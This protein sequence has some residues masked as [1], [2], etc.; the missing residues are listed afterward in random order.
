MVGRRWLSGVMLLSLL[1]FFSPLLFF[2]QQVLAEPAKPSDVRIVIDISGS[3][4][5]TDPEN[6]RI[7]AVNLLVELLPDGSQ[8]GIWTFGR[9]VNMLVPLATVDS[10]WRAQAKEK[11]ET[12]NSVGLQTNLTEALQ[13]ASWKV[14][15]DSGFDH[16]VILLTD[17]KL[18]MQQPGAP[19]DINQREK[20]RLLT[21]VLPD[22]IAAGARIHTLALSDAADVKTLQQISLETGGLFLT[23]TSA[24]ELLKAFL[25]AFDRAVPA[26]QVPMTDNQFEIDD[27]VQEFTALIFRQSNSKPTVLI[28]PDGS[29]IDENTS[30]KQDQV[31]WH[32]DLNFDLITVRQPQAGQWAADADVDPDNRVQILTDLKLRVSGLPSNI[33][34]GYPIDLE[35]A[36]T[37]KDAVLTD[38]TILS[39]TDISMTVTAPDGRTGSKLLSDPEALPDDGVF[40]ESLTRLSQQGEYQLE[41]IAAGRTFKRKQV[42]TATLSEPLAVSVTPDYQQQQL[43]IRVTPEVENIDT[44]LS[45]VIARVTSPDGSSVIQ[46]MDFV[47]D[48]NAWQLVLSDSKGPGAYE[49]LLNIRGVTANGSTFKSKPESIAASFPLLDPDA[50]AVAPSPQSQPAAASSNQPDAEAASPEMVS[51]SVEPGISG[52]ESEV[53]ESATEPGAITPLE[54]EDPK[55]KESAEEK[56]A[57]EEPAE[58]PVQEKPA[59]APDLAAQF[60]Q[61]QEAEPEAE[62]GVGWWVYLILALGNLAVFGGVG[63]WWFVKRKATEAA[64]AEMADKGAES[65]LPPDLEAPEF[66]ESELDG[67]F[68]AFDDDS[69]EEIG[70]ASPA[71]DMGAGADDGL[72]LDDDFAIDPDEEGGASPEEDWGEFDDPMDDGDKKDD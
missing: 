18:D 21:S 38:T 55:P 52:T 31:R 2:A 29:R 13:K 25:K 42:L 11:A 37:E 54:E 20:Q 28:A 44:T 39:L 32:N 19:S 58:Q 14:A 1:L 22:Y 47:G 30:R 40:R 57:G 8:A 4:K 5:Q 24:D 65:R 43:D 10:N 66:D 72:G 33:F 17:G 63:Y 34:A 6:L 69:E 23:A 60:E 53:S 56:P 35:M 9:Y 27:S 45:R 15:P 12:I 67:D 64:A 62:E 46:S 3:M 50:P 41:V 36:L 16:S 59:I 48:I 26:E 61:Q 70:S 49:V 71:P 68:D 7:P 51:D